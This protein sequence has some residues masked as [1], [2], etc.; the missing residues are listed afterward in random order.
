MLSYAGLESEMTARTSIRQMVPNMAS[1]TG[2]AGT[3]LHPFVCLLLDAH[4]DH[5]ITIPFFTDVISQLHC[6][7]LA[8][9]RSAF[10][11]LFVRRLT[12]ISFRLVSSR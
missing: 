11:G 5:I 2:L 9:G 1:V 7:A 3:T 10:D 8:V 4:R 6:I 12:D